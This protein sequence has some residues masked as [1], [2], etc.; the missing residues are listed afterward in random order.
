MRQEKTDPVLSGKSTSLDNIKESLLFKD[1][2]AD[3]VNGIIAAG[4]WLQVEP[5]HYIY[6]QGTHALR[7]FIVADGYVELLL[8]NDCGYQSVVGRIGPGGHFGETSLLT[9]SCNSIDT[10]A[11]SET[12]LLC[13]N[14][15]TFNT[16]LLAQQSIK[17]HLCIALAER[18]R[19]SFRDHANTQG[20]NSKKQRRTS[21]NA[22]PSFLEQFHLAT[23]TMSREIKGGSRPV[24]STISRQIEKAVGQLSGNLDPVLIS[25]ELGT[26]RR[27]LAYE[28]HRASAYRN[29]P[30]SEIDVLE[31]SA[32][33]IDVELFGFDQE[34]P[35]FSEIGH[36]GIFE[37]SA[38][39]TVVLYSAEHMEPDLQRQLS[40]IIRRKVFT[41]VGGAREVPLQSRI[42]LICRDTPRQ[43][44]GHNR[45]LPSLFSLVA[46]QHV[47][48]AP[49]RSHRKDIPE[50]VQYY[51]RRYCLQ[52]GKS[53]NEVE[54][55]TLGMIM[56]Y[57]WPGNLDEMASV[58]QR[59][60][61][62]G[63]SNHPLNSQ[64]LLGVPKPEGK[65]EFNLLRL[66]TVR[67]VLASP[68]YPVL[69]R[70]VIG[71]ILLF[72]LT[73]LLLGPAEPKK[74]LGLVL[75]WEVG[76]PLL[77]FF[78]FFLAR[79][80]C[81]ICGLALPGW[82]AQIALK[83]RRQTPEFIKRY[84]GWIAAS[85]CILLFW[86]ELA[87]NGYESPRLTAWIL[88]SIIT[89][90]FIFSIF[91]ERR[92][93]CRYLCPLGNINA[94]FSMSSILELRANSQMCMN[95]CSD[96][97]CYNGSAAVSGC[98][99]F[100]HPFMVD[101]NRDCILC[102]KCIK[103]CRQDSIHLNL[104]LAPQELWNQRSPRLEDNF[105]IVSLAGI[106]HPF[107]MNQGYYLL[108]ENWFRLL[109]HAQQ[110]SGSVLSCSM[111]FFFCILLH[112]SGYALF[113]LVMARMSGSSWKTTAAALGYG[114]IPL[115]LAAFLALYLEIL[116][117]G[118]SLVQANLLDF[119][120]IAGSPLPGRLLSRDAT[121]VLQCITIIGGLF[122]SLVACRNIVKRLPTE[123]VHSGF[124][125]YFPA[126]L[127][128]LSAAI[129][130]QLLL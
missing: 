100:R 112:L 50:L 19:V 53:I 125:L 101:N 130:L 25:G 114:Y 55:R 102:A 13:F 29:G 24:G 10:R 108:D 67:R 36:Y 116:M 87:W 127:L 94:L 60:V 77:V 115:L 4:H 54:D 88:L 33:Q 26:G 44:D 40:A 8:N 47:R 41:R 3:Q 57:D 52:Y 124:V 59:A 121:M 110:S 96:H 43:Q 12:T 16:L 90:A 58:M 89:G 99:M 30:Y 32:A 22:G 31:V 11:L 68:L 75:S 118:F 117:V 42:I 61:I 128:C 123:L 65:W 111:F 23:G 28:I 7:F 76:W 83:P 80:W 15:D 66:Q 39:G 122:A 18:L 79:T 97:S 92:V 5:G 35:A 72:V 17:H 14:A 64:I 62:L 51:L 73:T 48:A 6:R 104:R 37:K 74:N 56:N 119:F 106:F 81:S 63:R 85:L 98:P 105:L 86:V 103:N 93:W 82:L 95:H 109:G 2:D 69:P 49:L 45:L 78:F 126:A 71:L 1:I 46:G 120:G 113:A 21:R 9:G 70:L 20:S 84:S 129:Y 91:F 38:G 34:A 107:A 27:M